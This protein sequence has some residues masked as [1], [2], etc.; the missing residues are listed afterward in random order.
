MYFLEC[1]VCLPSLVQGTHLFSSSELQQKSISTLLTLLNITLGLESK[2]FLFLFSIN[3]SHR[4]MS[5]SRA[6]CWELQGWGS[7]I[8][9]PSGHLSPWEFSSWGRTWPWLTLQQQTEVWMSATGKPRSAVYTTKFPC[10]FRMSPAPRLDHT[11]VL[12]LLCLS[13]THHPLANQSHMST[14]LWISRGSTLTSE[15]DP[16]T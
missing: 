16:G 12:L 8:K 4:Y 5:R 10:G 15:G 7:Q 9:I 2:L 3:L 13:S 11:L 14:Y 6:P 1:P